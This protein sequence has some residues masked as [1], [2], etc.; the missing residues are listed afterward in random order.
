MNDF[1]GVARNSLYGGHID[2]CQS[3]YGLGGIAPFRKICHYNTSN[4]SAVSSNVVGVCFCSLT[5]SN[6]LEPN[7]QKNPSQVPVY[8]GDWFHILTGQMNGT[9]HSKMDMV[10]TLHHLAKS[11][12]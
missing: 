7:C 2:G 11:H 9:V 8:P 1:A 5:S 4:P 6:T 12:R 10:T 3:F